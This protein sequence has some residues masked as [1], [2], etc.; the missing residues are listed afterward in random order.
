MIHSPGLAGTNVEFTR[1]HIEVVRRDVLPTG[2]RHVA[3]LVKRFGLHSEVQECCWVI[4]NGRNGNVHT[5]TEIA[6]GNHHEVAVDIAL[7]L[8]AVLAAGAPAFAI[9]HNHPTMSASPSIADHSL[10][11]SIM[12]A[13]NVCGLLF[14]EHVIVEPT[15]AFYSFRDAGLILGVPDRNLPDRRN[16]TRRSRKETAR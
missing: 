2:G 6:R 4:A 14:E 1:L 7:V 10:T 16:G 13:A 8:T 9:A 5:I 12:D 3:D 15:G 11:H